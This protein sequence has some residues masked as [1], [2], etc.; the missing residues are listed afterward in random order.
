MTKVS[1]YQTRI[2]PPLLW[3]MTRLSSHIKAYGSRDTTEER[4]EQDVQDEKELCAGP[5]PDMDK[6]FDV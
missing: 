2:L 1:L 6:L 5:E 4:Q 3:L